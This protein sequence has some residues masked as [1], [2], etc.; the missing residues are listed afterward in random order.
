[1]IPTRLTSSPGAAYGSPADKS[2][3][4]SLKTSSTDL[5]NLLSDPETSEVS[6]WMAL[7]Y[8]REEGGTIELNVATAPL[9][10]TE[11]MTTNP[12]EDRCRAS[13]RP[14]GVSAPI[15]TEGGEI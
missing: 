12:T 13:A 10:A 14:S 9:E 8:P 4:R 7:M 3:K 15:T 5:T 1:M 2:G 6:N 11:A